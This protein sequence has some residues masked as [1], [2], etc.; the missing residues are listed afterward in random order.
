MAQLNISTTSKLDKFQFHDLNRDINRNHVTRLAESIRKQGIRQ[1][2]VVDT[3]GYVID[4]QHRVLAARS[5][6]AEGET[7][8]VPYIT[9]TYTPDIIAEMNSLQLAWTTRDWVH[10]HA[11]CGNE[12]YEQLLEIYSVFNRM[13]LSS[14]ACFLHTGYSQLH[15]NEV[16]KGNF[17]YEMTEDKLYILEATDDLIK[18]D[19]GFA[20]KAFLMAVMVLCRMDNFNVRRLFEK[21]SAN[22]SS[23]RIQSGNSNWAHHLVYW[24]NKGLRHGRL[25]TN[26]LPRSH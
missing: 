16:K 1:P 26:D 6:N 15:T 22:L 12:N 13:K 5:L 21:L 17:K 9:K 4:G 10:Y 14:L 20:T 18:Y 24:Y 19:K 23:V 8:K 2:I 7:V 3:H 11:K 25:S